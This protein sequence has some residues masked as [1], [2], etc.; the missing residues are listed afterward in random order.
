MILISD[1]VEVLFSDREY[2]YFVT[3]DNVNNKQ[4]MRYRGG[5]EPVTHDEFS[6]ARYGEHYEKIMTYFPDWSM[7]RSIG[8]E[9]EVFVCHY[10]E[11]I[12]YKFDNKGSLVRKYE[13]MGHLDTIYDIAVNANSIWCAYPTSH[14][15][16]KFSLG[17]GSL[18]VSISEGDIGMD[19][20][21]LFSYPESLT[22]Q[23]NI[24]YVSDMGNRRVCKVD[25]N[26]FVVDTHLK[27][28]GPVFQYE[29][30]GDEEFVLVDSKLYL[31]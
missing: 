18:E 11:S 22:L 16:K 29:Q 6:K 31:I 4:Y 12:I 25:L 24:L 7:S 3:S 27:V 28:D 23:E 1:S 15:V 20:G 19:S 9:G 8:N 17:D 5:S 30:L 14:T 26:T 10:Q 21:T 13:E 2:L